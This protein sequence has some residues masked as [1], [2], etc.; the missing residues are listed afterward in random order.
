MASGEFEEALE[1]IEPEGDG[2][3]G[4]GVRWAKDTFTAIAEQYSVD[5]QRVCTDPKARLPQYTQ[6][7]KTVGTW[8]VSQVL[9]DPEGHNDWV[10]SI[11]VDL[12]RS[13][14]AFRPILRLEQIGALALGAQ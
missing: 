3:D 2:P 13:R 14:E 12:A 6:I 10:M 1:L 5:H 9:V 4:Q 7:T 8:K 11:T